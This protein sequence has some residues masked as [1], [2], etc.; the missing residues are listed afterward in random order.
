MCAPHDMIFQDIMGQN[1]SKALQY[2]TENI[3]IACTP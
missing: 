2:Y 1:N 3:K